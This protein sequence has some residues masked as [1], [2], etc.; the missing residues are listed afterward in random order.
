MKNTREKNP[1]MLRDGPDLCIVADAE[2]L[3]TVMEIAERLSHEGVSATVLGVQRGEPISTSILLGVARKTR[4]VLTVE[5]GPVMG[6]L[7]P[8]VI[9]ALCK[10]GLYGPGPDS[11]EV[12][13]L[14]RVDG[15]MAAG[16]SCTEA[17]SHGGPDAEAIYRQVKAMLEPGCPLCADCPR[18]L[19]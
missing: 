5:D 10:E 4:R 8:K 19:C 1:S 7:G 13:T 16:G 18:M 3:S 2:T 12:K 15:F 6:G 9:E 14:G 17:F 11:V